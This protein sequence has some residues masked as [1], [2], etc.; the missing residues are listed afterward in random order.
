[1]L[2]KS[3][4]TCTLGKTSQALEDFSKG[5]LEYFTRLKQKIS[6]P[7]EIKGCSECKD[8]EKELAELDKSILD[9]QKDIQE[10]ENCKMYYIE[11]IRQCKNL[12]HDYEFENLKQEYERLKTENYNLT[13]KVGELESAIN[14]LKPHEKGFLE[15]QKHCINLQ[16]EIKDF[17]CEIVDPKSE[18]EIKK[19]FKKHLSHGW[20]KIYKD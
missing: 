11:T 6:H 16:N 14:W 12:K 7:P 3:T 9:K 8:Y 13:I 1:M 2:G 17:K 4:Q 19:E 20:G 15:L 10:Y 5:N 18:E